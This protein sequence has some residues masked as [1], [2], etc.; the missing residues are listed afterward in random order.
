M[1]EQ[2]ALI[3]AGIIGLST[4]LRLHE[5]GYD[6]RLF[7]KELPSETTSAVAAA[8]WYPYQVG[9]KGSVGR[10]ARESY[11]E[12]ERQIA[13]GVPGVLRMPLVEYFRGEP[14]IPVWEKE[15]EGFTLL[16]A[17]ELPTGFS[18]GFCFSSILTETSLYLPY[19]LQELQKRGGVVEQVELDS[20]EDLSSEYS[21]LIN[22]SGL[23]ARHLLGDD[24]LYPIR[25]QLTRTSAVE[26]RFDE[27]IVVFEEPEYASYIVPR[28]TD[29]V[30]GGTAEVNDWSLSPSL[31]SRDSIRKRCE[32]LEPKVSELSELDLLVGLRPGRP[33]VRVERQELPSSQTLIHNYGHGGAGFTLCWGC[34]D[35]VVKLLQTP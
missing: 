3:G 11:L 4:S 21:T 25:G 20:L 6:V 28:S 2:I 27:Q 5:A 29:C 35:E 17:S 23:G 14:L 19:L 13:A 15:V 1:S 7:A 24:S 22:C 16:Q 33:E 34:A 26:N 8:F 12:Y 30:L 31:E 32:E 9:T 18:S 10:W